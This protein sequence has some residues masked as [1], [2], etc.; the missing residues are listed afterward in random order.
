MVQI[1]KKREKIMDFADRFICSKSI[2]GKET[3]N[4]QE[5]ISFLTLSFVV[6]KNKVHRS[7]SFKFLIKF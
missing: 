4:I 3:K 2:K 7:L 6:S 1:S 5:K